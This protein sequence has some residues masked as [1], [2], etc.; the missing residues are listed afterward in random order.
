MYAGVVKRP[1]SDY[2]YSAVYLCI[3]Q[4]LGYYLTGDLIT[5]TDML[6]DCIGLTDDEKTLIQTEI[7]NVPFRNFD[8]NL[9]QYCDA[10][11]KGLLPTIPPDPYVR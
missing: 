4:H 9:K 1:L 2:G 10:W 11:K 5:F 3:R 7:K 8:G 6:D